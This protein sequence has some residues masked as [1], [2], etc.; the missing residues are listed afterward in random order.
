M[1]KT[2]YYLNGLET[3]KSLQDAMPIEANGLPCGHM[4]QVEKQKQ[5]FCSLQT[6]NTIGQNINL[7]PWQMMLFKGKLNREKTRETQN[8]K[9]P[10]HYQ[11]ECKNVT[12]PKGL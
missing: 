3:A 6:F 8:I 4:Q 9:I 12:V 7:K 10:A 1:N 2:Y 5:T 11:R